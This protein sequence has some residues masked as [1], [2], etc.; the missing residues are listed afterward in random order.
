MVWKALQQ[1]NAAD[2]RD[3]KREFEGKAR[4]LVD[5]S[6]GERVAGILRERGVNAKYAAEFGLIGR[7]D[8]D[9]FAAAW[10]DKRAIFTHDSDF[11]DDRRFPHHRNPGVVL[12][13]P[14]ADGSDNERLLECLVKTMLIA[15]KKRKMV[16]W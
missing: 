3:L 11:M 6:M 16:S 8:E 13:R 15:G 7:S 1:P 14:G 4:V 12:I 10:A 5:E 2:L 9:V